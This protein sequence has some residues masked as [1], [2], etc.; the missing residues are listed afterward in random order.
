MHRSELDH[1]PH[2]HSLMCRMKLENTIG[3]SQV[4]Q[5]WNLL[6]CLRTNIVRRIRDDS[7]RHSL[8]S[9]AIE[10]VFTHPNPPPEPTAHL[11]SVPRPRHLL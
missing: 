9:L 7:I 10:P 11:H 4:Q 8:T 1:R 6:I 3:L 2:V 5:Q